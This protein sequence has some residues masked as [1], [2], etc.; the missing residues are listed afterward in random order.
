MEFFEVVRKRRSVRAFLPKA[1]EDGKIGKIID[2][3]IA[4]P[5]AGNLQS[6]EIVIVRNRE[7]K[8]LLA[9]AAYAQSFVSEAPLV[10]VICANEKRSASRYGKRG[11]E[12]YCINDASIVAAYI[13]L[14]C[15]DLGLGS[16]WIGAFDDAA[17]RK[18]INAPE[19]ARSI[20]IIP[21]GYPA[22]KPSRTGRRKD[23]VHE[24]KF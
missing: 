24:N 5:S 21:I 3:A 11:K 1:V 12:L 2:C 18:I 14:A 4:S 23:I 15:A 19:W 8:E 17:V 16:V 7:T 20:A 22:E 6:Y 10:L 9:E 13:Q